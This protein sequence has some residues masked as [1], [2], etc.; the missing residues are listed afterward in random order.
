MKKLVKV[1]LVILAFLLCYG[2]IMSFAYDYLYK[3][4]IGYLDTSERA[5]GYRF[6]RLIYKEKVGSDKHTLLY[7]AK[8]NNGVGLQC[9]VG[10]LYCGWPDY[11]ANYF[12]K[13]TSSYYGPVNAISYGAT[14]GKERL[15]Y[16]FGT[17][18]DENTVRVVVTFI[19]GENDEVAIEMPLLAYEDVPNTKCYYYMGFDE[20]LS[21][22][23]S[24][25]VGYNTEDGLTFQYNG[26]PFSEGVFT[27]EVQ[28]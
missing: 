15:C 11:F 25:I 19:R 27:P 14:T 12:A 3:Y 18:S 26:Q 7:F 1:L 6:Y 17:T 23:P 8:S 16:L 13:E 9:H 28:N 4:P 20:S 22:Y 24:R 5:E 2:A 21:F 10:T